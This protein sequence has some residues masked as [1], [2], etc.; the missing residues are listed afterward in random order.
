MGT[1]EFTGYSLLKY[2][3]HLGCLHKY[4][5]FLKTQLKASLQPQQAE[6][7]Q[8]QRGKDYLSQSWLC[9]QHFYGAFHIVP[10]PQ[11]F[12][13][14]TN[15][16]MNEWFASVLS[17]PPLALIPWHC[18]FSCSSCPAPWAW[19]LQGSCLIYC[20]SVRSK[21]NLTHS[22]CPVNT[23]RLT[24]WLNVYTKMQLTG[25]KQAWPLKDQ[26]KKIFRLELCLYFH[27][28]GFCENCFF[29]TSSLC[30]NINY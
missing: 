20:S 10:N 18:L 22:R 11:I 27:M 8:I 5:S 13:E 12:I 25:K 9:P 19:W 17:V 3:F 21:H 4:S 15:E 2:P 6:A 16:W 30:G 1:P 28:P 24:E 23:G 29:L 26:K 7:Q 14:W